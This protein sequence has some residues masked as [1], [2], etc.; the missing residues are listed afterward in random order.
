MR[1]N[2]PVADPS[3][4]HDGS[5]P[6][7]AGE[8]IETG[9]TLQLDGVYPRACGGT[10]RR[11]YRRCPKPG[12]IPAHAGEPPSHPQWR[13]RR[14]VYPRA[15]GG[16]AAMS[17]GALAHTGV[18]PRACGGTYMRQTSP[19][20]SAGLS[21]RMRGNLPRPQAEH[22]IVGSIPA[23]AGEPTPCTTR[24]TSRWVYPR[25][26]GGTERQRLEI[27]EGAGLSPRMRGNPR[28]VLLLGLGFGSIPAHAGEPWVGH[29]GRNHRRVYPRAC[30]GTHRDGGLR[31]AHGGSIPAH[32]GE[33]SLTTILSRSLR[34]YPRA[35]G[36]TVRERPVGTARTGS[37]PAHAGEPFAPPPEPGRPRVY[38]RACGGTVRCRCTFGS[39]TGLS[40][41]M[42]GNHSEGEPGSVHGGS[43][44][45]HA[46]EPQ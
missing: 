36:G 32:A 28:H 29:A 21:P 4:E 41:R 1:G 24:K 38:P 31:R 8:P 25:A 13:P 26:C 16:T 3:R 2:R 35:C 6:A 11:L 7:H 22:H 19:K 30:G 5:I 34:V 39:E 15:C 46:G 23:H 43:I 20:S 12:S 18:Y 42:R 9:I 33:P 40:P 14:R 44:P 37:I 45:A 27:S 10:H 17:G